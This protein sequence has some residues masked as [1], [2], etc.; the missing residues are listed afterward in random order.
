MSLDVTQTETEIEDRLKTIIPRV[1]NTEV[2]AGIDPSPQG[3]PYMVVFFGDPIRTAGDHH[4]TSTRSDVL[5]GYFTVQVVGADFA[6]VR[7]IRDRVKNALVGFRPFDSGEI[8]AEGGISY[9]RAASNGSD[10]K[11]IRELGFSY[12]TNLTFVS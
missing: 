11:Y 1:Y 4:I 9:S 8:V 12:K 6:S 2:P 5:R 10:V 3:K 7:A